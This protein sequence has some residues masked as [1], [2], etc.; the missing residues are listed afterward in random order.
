[1]N[2]VLAEL[3]A[4]RAGLPAFG[5]SGDN[6]ATRLVIGRDAAMAALRKYVPDLKYD[7]QAAGKTL[8]DVDVW[9]QRNGDALSATMADPSA[10]ALPE[11]IQMSL[12]S[13]KAGAFIVAVFTTASSGL[14]PWFSGAVGSAAMV[15]GSINTEWARIDA[16]TRL[17]V[18]GGIVK[19]END[20]QLAKF[21]VPPAG[22]KGFGA[23][24]AVVVWAIVVA[25]VAMASLLLVYMY[26]AKRLELNNRLMRDLCEDAQKSGDS[27]TTIECISATKDL[28]SAGFVP[29]SWVGMAVI[30][31]VIVGGVYMAAKYLPWDKLVVTHGGDA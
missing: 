6:Y 26:S 22:M 23:V 15:G 30:G 1:M 10:S 5:K 9:E 12:G 28:Q 27:A 13:D 8:R 16:E 14:G 19:M 11:K 18:F 24:Q 20:G 25:V 29:T 2:E 31:G 3:S 17:S 7:E 21:F 4:H